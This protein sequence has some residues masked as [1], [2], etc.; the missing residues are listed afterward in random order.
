MAW[1][2]LIQLDREKS[3]QVLATLEGYPAMTLTPANFRTEIDTVARVAVATAYR[4]TVDAVHDVQTVTRDL[5]A[6]TGR[7]REQ[8]EQRLG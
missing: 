6:L 3:I 2:R 7:M 4:P 1:A 5:K 8:R